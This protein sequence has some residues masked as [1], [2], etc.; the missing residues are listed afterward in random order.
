MNP[1]CEKRL[2]AL[3]NTVE[4]LEIHDEIRKV[5][6]APPPARFKRGDWVRLADRFGDEAEVIFRVLGICGVDKV[7]EV[8]VMRNDGKIDYCHESRLVPWQP[9]EGEVVVVVYSNK[10]GKTFST[11]SVYSNDQNRLSPSSYWLHEVIPAPLG[12]HAQE[13]FK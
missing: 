12:N 10:F 7:G 11:P 3:E 5:A 2:R 1:D 8:E 13:W 4:L 6:I 9:R